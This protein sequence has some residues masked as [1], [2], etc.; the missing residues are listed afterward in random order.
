M[1]FRL[2]AKIHLIAFAILPMSW[3]LHSHAAEPHSLT[4]AQAI[5]LSGPGADFG[6]DFSL[7]AKI[8]FDHVNAG[9]GI[10]GQRLQYRQVDTG[11]NEARAVAAAR[12]LVKEGAQVLFGFGGDGAVASVAQDPAIRGSATA[13][14]APV[15]AGVNGGSLD[16]VFPLRTGVVDEVRAI[17][18]HLAGL[19]IK[20]FGIAVAGDYGRD[21]LPALEAEL[22]KQS[23]KLVARTPFAASGDG[24][25]Q[26]AQKIAQA[27]PQAVIV[28]A[29]TLAVAQFVKRYRALDPGAFLSAPS[30]VNIRTLVS[31]VGPEAARGLIIS[32][33]V[34]NPGAT[35]EVARE[36]RRL[37]ERY[38]DEPASQATLEGFIAAKALVQILRRS[39]DL[40][41]T[42]ILQAMREA[43]R[44]DVG[45]FELSIGKG[46]SAS[47][48][49]ELTVVGRDGKLLR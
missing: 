42:G 1:L 35:I 41:H 32:Q 49:V 12:G 10:A 18:T 47:S 30:L 16:N 48:F 22:A 3:I 34:P 25:S 37:M 7:G 14:F 11:G 33:V 20:T 44:L 13:V 9:G 8:Y 26:A 36:H 24:P 31:T 15:V 45:G 43:G 29:D 2:L 21:I 27:R 17:T 19:G 40:S 23:V 4:I 39:R 6:R 28:L 5:D 38:A 46:L